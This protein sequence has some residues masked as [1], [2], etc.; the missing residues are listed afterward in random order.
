MKSV[1]ADKA[2]AALREEIIEFIPKNSNLLD[3][4]SATG[5]L[6]FKASHKIGFGIG[7]DLDLAMIEFARGKKREL[8]SENIE[9]F[10]A[11]INRFEKLSEYKIDIATAT[12]CLH[13][14]QEED[15]L[16]T[17]KTMAAI[18]SKI[19][20]ADYEKAQTLSSKFFMEFDEVISSH[21]VRFREY[22]NRGYFPY[23]A[24]RAGLQI[25]NEQKSTIDGIVIWELNGNKFAE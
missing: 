3:V 16:E 25:V 14:M 1:T 4:G 7:V 8:K 11:D 5:D 12:L 23:L 17:L 24:K 10:H 22:R 2:L 19:V 9:F 6:L 21:Y 15:V 13:E 18:S 20:I